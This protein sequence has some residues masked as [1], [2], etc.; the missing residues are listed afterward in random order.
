MTTL[1]MR[2]LIAVLGLAAAHSALAEK[3]LLS[4]S[5][6]G[7][8]EWLTYSSGAAQQALP[9]FTNLGEAALAQSVLGQSAT[10][11]GFA[12]K[13]PE[14]RAFVS[15]ALYAEALALARG[16]QFDEARQRMIA[17]VDL[18]AR[19]GVSP[20]INDY[21]ARVA[22]LLGREAYDAPALTE[23]I[24][25]A[26]PFLDQ[27]MGEQSRDLRFLFQT[28]AWLSDYAMVA[29]SG[30]YRF[31]GQ[32]MMLGRTLR[33]LQRLEAPKGVI[34][35]LAEIK[36]LTSKKDVG[37]RE[38]KEVQRLVKKMQELLG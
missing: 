8:E 11:M 33:E 9:R 38:A 19:L 34:D 12:E 22:N 30:E 17:L 27:F 2:A 7:S 5:T 14:A 21:L 20:A 36:A 15:G 16:G 6:G 13:S 25:L 32:P 28:G 1:T 10:T 18:T 4:R 29:A 37:E 35:A 23:M 24:N 26:Q 3:D 31:L